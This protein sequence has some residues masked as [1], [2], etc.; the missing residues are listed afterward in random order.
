[1]LDSD[2]RR[3]GQGAPTGPAG[4]RPGTS[5][6]PPLARRRPPRRRGTAA[7][8][9]ATTPPARRPAPAGVGLPA[10]ARGAAGVDLGQVRVG[11]AV[12]DPDGILATPLVT[13][14]P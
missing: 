6:G 10:A 3:R 13:L 11:V 14:A 5:A 9:P 2:E 1:M 12:S 7:P 4:R 8:P